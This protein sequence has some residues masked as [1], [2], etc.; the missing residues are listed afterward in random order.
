[1][2]ADLLGVRARVEFEVAIA[3]AAT[4]SVFCAS[5]VVET[6]CLGRRSRSMG[7][8]CFA[9]WVDAGTVRVVVLSSS[10]SVY[11]ALRCSAGDRSALPQA[12]VNQQH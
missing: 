12:G 1:M 11:V 9:D 8:R 5:G 10:L 3:N 7:P 2:R 4:S 6:S